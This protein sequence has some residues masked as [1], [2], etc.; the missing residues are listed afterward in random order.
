MK[1]TFIFA[2][3]CALSLYAHAGDEHSQIDQ[4]ILTAMH[5]PMMENAFSQSGDLEYDFLANMMPHHQGAVDSSKLLLHFE[6]DKNLKQ[7]AQNIIKTQEQ[8]IKEF[9]SILENKNYIKSKLSQKEY[10]DFINKEKENTQTMMHAMHNT[11]EANVQKAYIEAM[12]A[13]HQGAIMSAKNFLKYSKDTKIRAIASKIIKDQEKEILE[14]KALLK[15]L[16]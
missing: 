8:E 13:H 11:Q 10:L 16:H 4:N 3:I 1:K 2:F 5:A 7:L 6:L 14:F 9:K 12:I 15:T